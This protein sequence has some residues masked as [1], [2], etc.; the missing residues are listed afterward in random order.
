ME[1]WAS[2]LVAALAVSGTIYSATRANSRTKDR[3]R[4]VRDVRAALSETDDEVT[5]RR[6]LAAERGAA[7]R[8]ELKL[9]VDRTLENWMVLALGFWGLAALGA[10]GSVIF[11][12]AKT[13]PDLA[14]LLLWTSLTC[15]VL[16]GVCVGAFT[17]RRDSELDK[18]LARDKRSEDGSPDGE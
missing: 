13:Q 17:L 7:L 6:L 5:R 11:N 10:V 4:T 2:V 3:I 9:R 15:S 18:I 14:N 12:A 16:A 8:L 1:V